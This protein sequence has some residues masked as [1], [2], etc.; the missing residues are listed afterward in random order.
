[1][2]GTPTFGKGSVQTLIGLGDQG[3]LRLTTARY[4]TPS[5]DS[6]QAKGIEPD[7]LVELAKL[8]PLEGYG[9]ENFR[10]ESDYNN[11]LD[12]GANKDEAA[13]GEADDAAPAEDADAD[14]T[15]PAEGDSTDIDAT[16][17]EAPA[18]G[19][20]TEEG[21][22][23]DEVAEEEPAEEFF[24]FQLVR[25]KDLIRGIAIFQN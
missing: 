10:Y 17:S 6:I 9:S 4:Y 11:A 7:I 15:A 19:E 13:E 5:G 25:A 24:D 12:D 3:G 21:D 8:E 2:L 18:E 20:G 1:M 23:E 22:E 14:E 16:D